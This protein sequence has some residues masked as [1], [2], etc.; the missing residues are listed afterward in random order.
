MPVFGTMPHG[1]ANL[2]DVRFAVQIAQSR[3]HPV[4]EPWKLT[5]PRRPTASRKIDDKAVVAE[6]TAAHIVSAAADSGQQT[7]CASEVD[8]VDDV[9]DAGAAGDELRPLVNARIPDLAGVI[10]DLRPQAQ[11]PHREMRI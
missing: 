5:I 8:S 4:L 2:E 10:V 9:G 11:T 6:G 1:T 3:A 7:V